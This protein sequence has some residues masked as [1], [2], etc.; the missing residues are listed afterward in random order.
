MNKKDKLYII[1]NGTAFVLTPQRFP[2]INYFLHEKWK[3]ITEKYEKLRDK[4]KHFIPVGQLPSYDFNEQEWARIE[5]EVKCSCFSVK[6][7]YNFT[8]AGIA[9]LNKK[10]KIV[11][12]EDKKESSFIEDNLKKNN[13]HGI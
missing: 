12:E 4:N 10:I 2:L 3:E 11:K 13:K 7:C 9:F 6:L 8:N 1:V 5:K